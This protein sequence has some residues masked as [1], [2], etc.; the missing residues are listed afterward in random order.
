RPTAQE[1]RAG[2]CPQPELS[3][4]IPRCVC[5]SCLGSNA[6]AVVRAV[7]SALLQSSSSLQ[8]CTAAER[9]PAVECLFEKLTL[10]FGSYDL[11][12]TVRCCLQLD[13]HDTPVAHA[14]QIV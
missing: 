5:L 7:Q 9:K 4:P 3:N 2:S 14:T 11:A 1:A 8:R 10:L 6:A 12:V 13:V